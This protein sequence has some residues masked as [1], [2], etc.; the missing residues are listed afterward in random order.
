MSSHDLISLLGQPTHATPSA[1]SYVHTE[2]RWRTNTTIHL[3]GGVFTGFQGDWRSRTHLPAERGSVDWIVET[4][5][6][7]P[8]VGGPRQQ[9]LEPDTIRYIFDR[10]AE[11]GPEVQNG[12]WD[13]LCR[14]VNELRER[15]HTDPRVLPIVRKRFQEAGI[16]QHYAAWLLHE[17]D[18]EGSRELFAQRIRLTMDEA[19]KITV[20]TNEEEACLTGGPYD[21]LHNLLNFLGKSHR[22]GVGFI[23]EAMDHPHPDIRSTGYYFWDCVPKE[24]ARPRLVRGIDDKDDSVREWSSWAFAKAFGARDDLPLLKKRL[25]T[26]RDEVVLQNLKIA[27]ARLEREKEKPSRANNGN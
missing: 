9:Q 24:D 6:G 2:E 17:C 3:K 21:D 20:A 12:D 10:F 22:Q 4:I 7:D 15:G 25:S 26:E 13:R 16:C 27:I 8:F 19:R 1:L 5:E 14:A 18:P 23:L 11:I